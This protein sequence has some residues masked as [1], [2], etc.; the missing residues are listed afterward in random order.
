[1]D[2]PQNTEGTAPTPETTPPT[3]PHATPGGA[4]VST[5]NNTMVMGILAYIGPLVFIPLLVEKHDQFVRYHVRQGLVIFVIDAGIWILG[6]MMLPYM[7]T[8]LLNLGAIILSVLGIVNVVQK[9]QEPIPLVGQF[10]SYFK[11]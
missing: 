7:L 4:P 9:K 1:M 2:Q 3:Q 10:S 11:I 8:N 6:E 5:E